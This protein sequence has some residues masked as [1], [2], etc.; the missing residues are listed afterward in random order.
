MVNKLN[1]KELLKS[2]KL[3]E[4]IAFDLETTGLNP[5]NDSIT[6]I[7]AYRFVDGKPAEEYSTLVKPTIRIPDE[8]VELTGITNGMVNNAPKI[9]TILPKLLD[10]IGTTPL[11][12]HNVGFDI[13]FIENQL[14]KNDLR[15]PENIECYDTHTLSRAFLFFHHEFNLGGISEYFGIS[16]EG[17]HRAGADT[18]NT[19]KIFTELVCEASSYPLQVIQ[20]IYDVIQNSGIYNETLFKNI[21]RSAVIEKNVNGL[22]SST[23]KK[24]LNNSIFQHKSSDEHQDIPDSVNNWFDEGGAISKKWDGYEPRKTQIN[25][26]DDVFNAFQRGEILLAEAGTGLGKSLAYL[27]AGILNR[28]QTDIPLVVSTYTKNLQDQLFYKDIPQLAEIVNVDLNVVILK[29]RRNYLCKTRLQNILDNSSILTSTD[30]ES[31]IPILVWEKHTKSG[32]I[33]ECTGFNLRNSGRV[34]RLIRSEPGYCTNN[35]CEKNDGCF[36]GK[37]RQKIHKADVIVVNHSLFINEVMRKTSGLPDTFNYVIDEGHNLVAA[38][39]DQLI[40]QMGDRSFNDIF[41]FISRKNKLFKNKIE[42]LINNYPELEDNLIELENHSKEL[43]LALTEFF[44]SYRDNKLQ[45]GK[46]F[47]YYEEKFTY[48]SG[49]TEFSDVYP[50]PFDF[51]KLLKDYQKKTEYFYEILQKNCEEANR[52]FIRELGVRFNNIQELITIVERTL[53]VDSSD[54]VWSSFIQQGRKIYSFLNCAPRDVSPILANTIFSREAGGVVCSATLAVDNEFKYLKKSLGIDQLSEEKTVKEKIYHSPFFYED[55]MSVFTFASNLNVNSP[56]YM[57]AVAEQIDRLSKEIPR[58]MLVLCTAYSQTR[59]LRELL[60][61]NMFQSERKLFVQLPGGNRKSLIRGYKKHP[62]S[63]LIGTASFWEGV[64]FPGDLVEI[65][66]IV[67]IPFANPKEPLVIANIEKYKQMGENAFMGFQ[68]PDATVRFKQGFGRL[69]RSM[70][71]SG[72][73]ILTDPRLLKSQYGSV[74]LNSLPVTITKP[75]TD[76]E[77]VIIGSKNFL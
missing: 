12:G 47:T 51:L 37:I 65:L 17:A 4:F 15:L 56:E 23:I 13:G 41:S 21:I 58:R 9:A 42:D 10:F 19:G 1:I 77:S 63:I 62:H 30:C 40:C 48:Y 67:K 54:I 20:E 61:S 24:E 68:V 35:R 70:E 64:D 33:S 27:S 16:S 22:I 75:Y 53:N 5:Q 26:A 46:K 6:E 7:S 52:S 31:L 59:A 50:T 44:H 28:K 72:I 55:Q 32:D 71:D 36:L 3:S 73:C 60:H 29:G 69:I 49:E 18:L 34:W 66:M 43:K 39:W 2:L 45:T 25:M 74:I 14:N 76:I 11:V 8:I 38:A 57:R